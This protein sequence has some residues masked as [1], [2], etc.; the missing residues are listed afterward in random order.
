MENPWKNIKDKTSEYIADCDKAAIKNQNLGEKFDFSILPHPYMGD[1]SNAEIF[2]LN[3]NPNSGP[4]NNG[5]NHSEFTK[6]HKDI[7]LNNLEHKINDYPLY[8]INA[9]FK[10]YFVYKWWFRH[11]QP[12]IKEIR[13]SQKVSKKIFEA[14]Y[15]PYFSD[16]FIYGISL[17]SQR[18]TFD[19]IERAIEN[20]KMIIIMR[21]R[22]EWETAIPKLRNY[23][24]KFVLHSAQNTIIS[25]GNLD[26]GKFEKII[27]QI[28]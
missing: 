16:K 17:P 1:P 28:K 14:E 3:A 24:N 19:I 5:I 6:N 27:K 15:V 18:Y 22:G 23:G 26:D 7:A 4:L 9:A 20:N 8:G 13:N 2:L 12:I 25:R 11:L 21:A 10:D